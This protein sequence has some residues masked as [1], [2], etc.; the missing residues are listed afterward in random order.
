[1]ESPVLPAYAQR[2]ISLVQKD[3]LPDAIKKNTKTFRKLLKQIPAKKIDYSYAPGK[4]TIKQL[5]Q[6]IIDAER[7]FAYRALWFARKDVQP[8][9]GFDENSWAASADV[10]ARSWND[11]V[12]EYKLV[13]KAT[14][15]LF[16]S[17]KPK[18]LHATGLSNN[19][20]ISV[21]ALGYL[22]AGHVAHHIK[23]IEER[24]I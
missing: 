2:Y 10:S 17:F 4:W 23:I 24:Y 19:F 6:H 5:L 1:M 14:A 13:R 15:L 3:R 12:E 7:V 18:D 22:C 21:G 8:L 16:N 20:E 11:M 9:P